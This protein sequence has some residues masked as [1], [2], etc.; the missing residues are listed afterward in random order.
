MAWSARGATAPDSR[1]AS[2]TTTCARPAAARPCPRPPRT[3]SRLASTRSAAGP[4]PAASRWPSPDA[5]RKAAG[6]QPIIAPRAWR[7]LA[8][9]L[10]PE[11]QMS[12]AGPEP[13]RPDPGNRAPRLQAAARRARNDISRASAVRKRIQQRPLVPRWRAA[14]LPDVLIGIERRIVGPVRPTVSRGRLVKP[15]PQ[16]RHRRR[17]GPRL[18]HLQRRVSRPP[19]RHAGGLSVRVP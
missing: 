16:P 15:L 7:P 10:P 18:R 5:N 3:R 8:S 1:T 13:R 19:R 9:R 6:S 14:H 4:S 11:A 2:S 12:R 17:S